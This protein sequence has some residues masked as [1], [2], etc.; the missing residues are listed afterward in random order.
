M[1]GGISSRSYLPI[2][3]VEVFINF[4]SSP[5]GFFFVKQ[6]YDNSCV[7][8]HLLYEYLSIYIY[9]NDNYVYREFKGNVN[10]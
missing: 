4:A 2:T 1:E 8:V 6:L 7:F 5:W 9:I 3:E 10:Q